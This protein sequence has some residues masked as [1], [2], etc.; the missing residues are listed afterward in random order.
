MNI[1][2]KLFSALGEFLPSGAQANAV[3]IDVPD[4]ST[5]SEILTALKVPLARCHMVM[6]NGM[7]HDIT[8][9]STTKVSSGDTLAVWP[10]AG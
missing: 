10:P 5:I 1:T 7:Q 2:L 3:K 8:A 4:D 6:I 9:I